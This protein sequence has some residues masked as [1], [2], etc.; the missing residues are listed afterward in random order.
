MSNFNTFADLYQIV[1]QLLRLV[2]DR[3]ENIVRKAFSLFLQRCLPQ[4][5]LSPDFYMS[6]VQVF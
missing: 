6:A 1:T 3:V 4:G 5:H 2:R